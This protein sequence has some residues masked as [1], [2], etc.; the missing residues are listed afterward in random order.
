MR[1]SFIFVCQAGEL[2]IK[3]LLL[4]ASLREQMACDCELIAAVP[5]PP[6]T[7]G[8]CR[9]E[10]LDQLRRWGVR[11]EPIENRID[12]GYPI[13]NKLSCLSLPVEGDKRVFLDSDI[14]FLRPFT[15]DPRFTVPFNA[16]PADRVTWGGDATIWPQLYALAGLSCP[17]LR[18]L[19][20][21]SQELSMPYFNAGVVAV[22]A[23]RPL[24]ETWLECARLVR[25]APGFRDGTLGLRKGHLDQLALPLAV[26]KLGLT[27]DCLSETYNFPGHQKPVDERAPPIL[28]HY[29]WPQILRR[30]PL[31]REA[32]LRLAA[33]HPVLEAS[34]AANP[35][36]A[37]LLDYRKYGTEPAAEQRASRPRPFAR[38][39]G[40]SAPP[41]PAP[42]DAKG[43]PDAELIVTG[44]PRSGTSYLC[45]VLNRV[46]DC[47]AINEP[48]EIFPILQ[49]PPWHPALYY[50]DLRRAI[51]DGEAVSNK[52]VDGRPIE[53][54][55]VVDRRESWHPEVRTRGFTLATKNTL[56]YL[57]RLRE[58]R[59]GL[60]NA[61]VVA[62]VRD[63][64]RT[65]ASWK[66]TFA[67]LREA[68]VAGIRVGGIDDPVLPLAH[69]LRL[70]QIPRAETP[71]LRRALFWR[72]LAEIV[73]EY[74]DDLLVLRYEDFVAA[75]QDHVGEMWRRLGRT[76]SWREPPT[77]S[78]RPERPPE[79]TPAEAQLIWAVCGST[80]E[81]FGY[82]PA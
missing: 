60:P 56:A 44:I 50:R 69:R 11:I 65:I 9:P 46:E 37:K 52:M 43:P 66:R 32:V 73:L 49:T 75:P 4:V 59:K 1:F 68:D 54:T 62:C 29:H 14:L 16:K 13:G 12:T 35:A 40:R 36:W 71:E 57:A 76:A 6:E 2:E 10:T 47:V 38:L 25:D 80:A 19:V 74:E 81:R 34:M 28:F 7:W 77:P 63:P 18:V 78:T 17:D 3:A 39:L 82:R 67:H 64:V 70:E 26:A 15:A 22:D 8:Q 41:A 61:L 33:R 20:S 55:A 21:V 5:H 42:A 48:T 53:D 72:H 23:D 58:I 31:A 30:E 27:V 45:A 79:I 51:L 24:G